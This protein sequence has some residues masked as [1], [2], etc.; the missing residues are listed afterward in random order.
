VTL[1]LFSVI[2]PSYNRETLIEA[3]LE[4]VF[5][6]TFTDYEIIVVDDQSKD[7]TCDVV[8]RYGDRVRLIEQ[9]NGGPGKARNTGVE[10]AKGTY[11]A[12]LDSDDLWFPWS[13]A[14]FAEL[15]AKHQPSLIL[16]SALPFSDEA[17]ARQT[18]KEPERVEV[19]ADYL[20]SPTMSI[21]A[22]AGLMVVRKDA[23]ER[24]GRFH[25]EWMICEDTELIVRLGA[26]PGFIAV[27]APHTLAYRFTPGS[28]MTRLDG[29]VTAMR[30]IAGGERAGRYPGGAARRRERLLVLGGIGRAA[31]VELLR[32]RRFGDA[33]RAYFDSFSWQLATGKL[34]FAL[35]FPLV[36]ALSLMA[37]ALGGRLLNKLSAGRT[38]Q[39]AQAN[40]APAGSPDPPLPTPPDRS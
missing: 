18:V 2:I 8:R 25:H 39:I 19:Y 24:V 9:T 30:H 14:F 15:I 16:G 34:K 27:R 40:P 31:S 12:F 29:Y 4:S 5:A 36:W 22:G 7:R 21:V 17:A 26:E 6:Q 37:P 11:L 1:P 20:A 3:T 13:L 23:F 10:V 35:G 33:W 32:G 28:A 38:V